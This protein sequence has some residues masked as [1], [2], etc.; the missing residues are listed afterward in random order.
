MY[1]LLI[2]PEEKRRLLLSVQM[3]LRKLALKARQWSTLCC[4]GNHHTARLLSQSQLDAER[5]S[6]FLTRINLYLAAARALQPAFVILQF[7]IK[8]RALLLVL[9]VPSPRYLHGLAFKGAA[10]CS[11]A[12][13]N[14]ERWRWWGVLLTRVSETPTG[15]HQM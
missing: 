6:N 4:F 3:K 1:L 14:G 7:L 9:L 12:C 11:V 13:S 8:P 2:S 5:T 10:A 15:K